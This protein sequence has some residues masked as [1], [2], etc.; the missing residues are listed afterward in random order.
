MNSRPFWPPAGGWKRTCS[1]CEVEIIPAAKHLAVVE[2]TA[3][4]TDAVLRHLKRMAGV[5][6][7]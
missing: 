4:F 7:E 3:A 2:N 6:A 1:D 5:A